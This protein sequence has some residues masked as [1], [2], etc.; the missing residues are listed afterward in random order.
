[1][2]LSP[3]CGL[4]FAFKSRINCLVRWRPGSI[5]YRAGL[6]VA[7]L[8]DKCALR[9]GTF[10]RN[11][12]ARISIP[13]A[14]SLGLAHTCSLLHSSTAPMER[15]LMY[16]LQPLL[17]VNLRLARCGPGRHN[18]C[19]GGQLVHH[20]ASNRLMCLAAFSLAT[21]QSPIS[22]ESQVPQ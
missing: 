3:W 14:H 10:V 15:G 21:R 11:P 9:E 13:N 7:P 20:L 18:G 8:S 6:S 16:A 1:M 22:T 4:Q 2:A 19:C 12:P 17:R 5:N